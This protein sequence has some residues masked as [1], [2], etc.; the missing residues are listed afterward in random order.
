MVIDDIADSFDYKNKYA[1]IEYL[2]DI[3]ATDK[4]YCILLSHNFDF[5]RTISGRLGLKRNCKSHAEKVGRKLTLIH[6][7]YQKNPFNHWKYNLTT[8]VFCISAIPFVRN[9]AEYCGLDNEY[10]KLT[11][12]LHVKA[13]TDTM[14]LD[15]LCEIYKKILA[16]KQHIVLHPEA[17]LVIDLINEAADLVFHA[18][19]EIVELE[20]KITLSI[21]IRLFAERHMIRAINNELFIKSITKKQTVRLLQEYKRLALSRA[22][23]IAILEQ[24]NLMTPENIHLNSFMY[25]PILDLGIS[26]LKTLYSHVKRLP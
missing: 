9:L 13:D 2:K 7:K 23:D 6:E 18:Q 20:E 12:L 8:N 21:A 22:Q 11:S 19:N 25:E 1:I 16:D 17:K 10:T 14:T 4:F 5:Y 24:V 26:H 3:S 15:M